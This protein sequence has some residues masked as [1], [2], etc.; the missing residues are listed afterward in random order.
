MA[1]LLIRFL[2]FVVGL[3]FA[4]R[5]LIEIIPNLLLVCTS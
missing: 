3:L 1:Q 4:F 5:E 2:P